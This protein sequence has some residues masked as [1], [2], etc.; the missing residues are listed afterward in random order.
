MELLAERLQGL[1]DEVQLLPVSQEITQ[2]PDYSSP[3]RGLQY[4]GRPNLRVVKRGSGP[5]ALL[6]NTHLDVVPPSATH[7]RPFEPRVEDGVVWG[8]GACDAKGQVACAYGLLAALH[9]ASIVP[10][11]DLIFH[12]VIE[13][14]VGGNGTVAM[15]RRGE[16]ADACVVLEPSEFVIL[17]QIRGAVWF[18]ATVYGQAGHSGKPG[19]TVSALLK[20]VSAMDAL[21]AYHDRCIAESRGHYPLFDVFENPA[22][23]TIGQ[24]VAGDWPAQAP[25][26]ATFRG[27]LGI[28]PDR[29]KE[30]V[31][32]EMQAAVR[33]SGDPWLAEN[34]EME[35][36]YR[37]DASVIDPA[38]PLVGALQRACEACGVA[39]RVSAMT[40]SCDA[41]MYTNQLSI[42]TL[43]FGP[44]SLG[45]AHGDREHIAVCDVLKGAEILGALVQEFGALGAGSGGE[46]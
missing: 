45:V 4:S 43:V 24:M 41:W 1:A 22:P 26:K 42:P 38:H 14:E 27:V 13:E 30:Q 3:I 17:P 19:G 12:F 21:A 46:A 2:D 40:A 34:F 25:Q 44:G 20:A 23:L 5:G 39:P 33:E 11:V 29:T 10:P 9:D 35:F 37:H 7:D 16:K 6:F 15:V 32:A 8:R 36:T 31:M 28:L 18:D